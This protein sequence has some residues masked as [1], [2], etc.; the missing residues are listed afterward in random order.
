MSSSENSAAQARPLVLLD[1]QADLPARVDQFSEELTFEQT[2][3]IVPE[4]T[5][6]EAHAAGL[7]EGERRGR[8]AAAKELAPVIARFGEVLRAMTDVRQQRLAEA[9][10]EIVEVAAEAARRILHGE[11][12]QDGDVVV[13]MARACIE[14]AG[15]EIPMTLH[16]APADA[17]LLRV[18]LAELGSELA[19]QGLTLAEDAT[20]TA[21]RV[22]LDT[23]TRCYDGRPENVLEAALAA[24]PS[25]VASAATSAVEEPGA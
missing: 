24:A 11:L 7:A 2:K 1:L 9:E 4:P 12:S 25:A 17:E 14:E 6:A 8:E 18:H 20:L 19:D 10:S 15:H 3:E 22:V 23:P 13:R 16:V 21:G 5:A